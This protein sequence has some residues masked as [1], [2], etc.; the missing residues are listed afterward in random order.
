MLRRG[1]HGSSGNIPPVRSGRRQTGQG[2]AEAAAALGLICVL[3]VAGVLVLINCG[4]AV[5]F[6]TKLRSVALAGANFAAGLPE[7]ESDA[8]GKTMAFVNGLLPR[9]S[10][11]QASEL[12][13]TRDADGASVTI[14]VDNLPMMAAV[15]FLPSRIKLS[16]TE[17]S[18]VPNRHSAYV[19]LDYL[20]VNSAPPGEP[21]ADPAF[22]PIMTVDQIDRTKPQWMLDSYKWPLSHV[23]CHPR[24]PDSPLPADPA[25]WNAR[26]ASYRG[27]VG[28]VDVGGGGSGVIDYATKLNF[29][30]QTRKY[31]ENRQLSEPYPP[32]P[33]PQGYRCEAA[34]TKCIWESIPSNSS[35]IPGLPPKIPPP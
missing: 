22:L 16:E 34:A 10:L 5:Y 23:I 3:T 28:D 17:I 31:Q 15:S 29:L 32:G 30:K 21:P 13:V 27:Y 11:P 6:K 18:A 35:G 1:S 9:L 8:R 20:P 4:T 26:G 33:N 24:W 19:W 25:C 14:T 12:I 2:L 7:N